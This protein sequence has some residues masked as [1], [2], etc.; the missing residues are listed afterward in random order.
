VIHGT[1]GLLVDGKEVPETEVYAQF[2][3]DEKLV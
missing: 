1:G 2:E 3:K